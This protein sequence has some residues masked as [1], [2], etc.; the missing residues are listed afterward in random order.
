MPGLDETNLSLTCQN[1]GVKDRRCSSL[2]TKEV[3]NQREA[4][5]FTAVLL[6]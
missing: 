3:G 6:E 4:L 5:K 1:N 2:K